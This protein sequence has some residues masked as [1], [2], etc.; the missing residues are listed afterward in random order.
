RGD[1]ED[2]PP[3]RVRHGRGQDDLQ[4]HDAED[5]PE[6]PRV[7]ADLAA[8]LGMIAEDP[9]SAVAVRMVRGRGAQ[10]AGAILAAHGVGRSRSRWGRSWGRRQLLVWQRG[11]DSIQGPGETAR[12]SESRH[13]YLILWSR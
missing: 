6:G 13:K 5:H 8:D 4:E 3:R 1:E 9:L 7:R 12:N 11:F 10:E 2:H